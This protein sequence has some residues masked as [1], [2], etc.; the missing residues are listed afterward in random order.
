M[1]AGGEA[2]FCHRR[3]EHAPQGQGFKAAMSMKLAGKV[4]LVKAREIVTVPSSSGWRR[5]SSGLPVELGQLVEEQHAVVGQRYPAGGRR[6]TAA[7]E[8]RVR[9]R[10]VQSSWDERDDK[11]FLRVSDKRDRHADGLSETVEHVGPKRSLSFQK[12]TKERR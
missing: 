10:V 8:A 12:I 11:S 5:T 6:G 3:P 4:V 9:D 2:H 1:G 7:H